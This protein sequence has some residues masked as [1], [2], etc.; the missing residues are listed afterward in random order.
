MLGIIKRTIRLLV[1]LIWGMVGL[2]GCAGLGV[3]NPATGRNE[4]IVVSTDAE[5]AMGRDV[6]EQ[7]LKQ[8][9]LSM[10]QEQIARVERVG[11]RL[12]QISDR[13]DYLYHFYVIEKDELNAFTIPG[14]NI[15]IFTGLLEKFKTDDE[16]AGV[17]AHEIGH[18]AARHTIKKFQAAL[19]YE[20]VG[21]AI[22]GQISPDQQRQRIAAMGA[23][24][25]RSLVF[26]AYGR[27]DEYE[28]DRLGLKYMD[29]AGYDVE[30]MIK[31]LELLDRESEGGSRV[32]LILR[33][34]PYLKDR[35]QA[36]QQEIARMRT[37]SPAMGTGNI[38]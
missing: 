11:Q 7:T 21:G 16:V 17:L 26:S 12:A 37:E 5:V 29:L 28:A 9:R 31:I 34:H 19:G 36:V 15:Y 22:I 32:P 20:I 35:I 8:F 27:Q 25:L 30:G 6:H 3:Y 24:V 18:C 13:Q 14:G 38:R 1:V 10:N 4:F 2:T 23:D 33:S